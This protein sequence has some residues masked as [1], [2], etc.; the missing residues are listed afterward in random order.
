M[1][2]AVG[3]VSMHKTPRTSLSLHP[4]TRERLEA[5]KLVESESL[6]S[7]LTRLLD[8]HDARARTAHPSAPREEAEA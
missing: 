8:E 3:C 1:G 5:A 2:H 7:V 4:P 6:D